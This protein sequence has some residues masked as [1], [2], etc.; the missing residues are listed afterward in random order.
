MN[1]IAN[2]FNLDV[3]YFRPTTLDKREMYDE[4]NM[5]VVVEKGSAALYRKPLDLVILNDQAVQVDERTYPLWPTF[6]NPYQDMPI[7][8]P[9]Q[10]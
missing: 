3:Y 7:T 1:R 8:L 9:F 2:E 6:L 4:S 10:A 5:N